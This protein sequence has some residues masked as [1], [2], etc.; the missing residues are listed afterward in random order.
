VVFNFLLF[1]KKKKKLVGKQHHAWW[2]RLSLSAAHK[3]KKGT[4][5]TKKKG[6]PPKTRHTTKRALFPRPVQLF[7]SGALPFKFKHYRPLVL[8]HSSF[9]HP[10]KQKK[11]RVPGIRR[12]FFIPPT[13][14]KHPNTTR[15][16][17]PLFLCIATGGL[18]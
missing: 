4:K 9:V 17:F 14:E 5:R 1:V 10:N 18:F 2:I 11:G 16:G 15:W 3:A 8:P 12:F 6:Q 7:L 13:T